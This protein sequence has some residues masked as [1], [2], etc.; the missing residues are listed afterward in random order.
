MLCVISLNITIFTTKL[1][2]PTGERSDITYY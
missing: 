2:I 1:T